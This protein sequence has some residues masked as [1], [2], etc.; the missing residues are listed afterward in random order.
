MQANL[1]GYLKDVHGL[2]ESRDIK[3]WQKLFKKTIKAM[4]KAKNIEELNRLF[5][6][7]C[8]FSCCSRYLTA[9]SHEVKRWKFIT[10]NMRYSLSEG[11]EGIER[12]TR[13]VT[14]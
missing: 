13:I 8:Y 11:G 4:H 2:P 10:Q 6:D 3:E 14:A 5:Q 12:I 1:C 7:S 9:K